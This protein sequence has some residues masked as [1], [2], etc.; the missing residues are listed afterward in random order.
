[1]SKV[2]LKVPS[3]RIERIL[4]AMALAK[5]ISGNSVNKEEIIQTFKNEGIELN[6]EIKL[7]IIKNFPEISL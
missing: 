4:F 5:G 7:N 6:D 3:D 1:M 2:F